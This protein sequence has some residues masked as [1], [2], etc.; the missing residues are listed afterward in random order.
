M[1][2]SDYFTNPNDMIAPEMIVTI[3]IIASRSW[4]LSSRRA[5]PMKLKTIKNQMNKLKGSD[6]WLINTRA[7]CFLGGP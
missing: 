5:N 2:D 4:L 3:R 6:I 7:Q 1:T